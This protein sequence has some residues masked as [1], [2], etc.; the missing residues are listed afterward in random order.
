MTFWDVASDEKGRARKRKRAELSRESSVS[1]SRRGANSFAVEFDRRRRGRLSEW[2]LT[3]VRVEGR[4]PGFDEVVLGRWKWTGTRALGVP[5]GGRGPGYV[6]ELR[7]DDGTAG[8]REVTALCQVFSSGP[9]GHHCPIRKGGCASPSTSE[10]ESSFQ[11]GSAKSQIRKIILR[12]EKS[13][14]TLLW[15][16]FPP[17]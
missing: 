16:L 11:P 5:S 8:S 4:E 15:I 3:G 14:V 13:L 9:L 7:R 10:A 2:L 6:V 12:P 17:F 1:R